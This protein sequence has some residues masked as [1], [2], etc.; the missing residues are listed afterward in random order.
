MGYLIKMNNLYYDVS[1][2]SYNSSTH[3][4][5]PLEITENIILSSLIENSKL[6]ITSLGDEITIGDDTFKPIDRFDQFILTSDFKKSISACATKSEYEL[7]CMKDDIIFELSQVKSIENIIINHSGNFK[8]VFSKDSG[9]TWTTRFN[10]QFIPMENSITN[11]NTFKQEMLNYGI[12]S[13]ELGKINFARQLYDKIRICILLIKDT[14][15]NSLGFRYTDCNHHQKL[16]KE[17]FDISI[18]NSLIRVIP[19]DKSPHMF[20]NI[21]LRE[22]KYTNPND[23][24]IPLDSPFIAYSM[25][26]DNTVTLNWSVVA[27]ASYYR[28]YVNGKNVGETENL[29]YTAQLADSSIYN[30]TVRAYP[31]NLVTYK[32]SKYSN[33]ITIEMYKTLATS[34]G[35]FIGVVIN[36]RTYKLKV[37]N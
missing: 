17:D 30:I 16:N 32:E 10:N 24:R 11:E 13:N 15:I 33:I 20:V 21:L 25:N 18:Y 22:E 36:G 29:Q 31:S 26:T 35:T 8:L 1:E 27:N 4:Y 34:D 2:E 14:T 9:R 3:M 19:K 7:I 5:N 28:I 6:D 23:T 12:D 37:V